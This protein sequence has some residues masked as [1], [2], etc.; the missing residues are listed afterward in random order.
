[1]NMLHRESVFNVFVWR[2]VFVECCMLN[3]MLHPS[4]GIPE[5]I[6]AMM[7]GVTDLQVIVSILLHA[8]SNGHKSPRHTQQQL[9]FLMEVQGGL[10]PVWVL[11]AG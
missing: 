11:H 2:V 5:Q 4:I 7:K 8:A 3:V 9:V 6:V 1:M 10:V